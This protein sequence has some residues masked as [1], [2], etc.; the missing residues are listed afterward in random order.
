MSQTITPATTVP[1]SPR[2]TSARW[3]ALA[4]VV[5][6]A[7]AIYGA[8]GDPHPSAQQESAVPFICAV[9]VVVAAGLYGLLLPAGLR[10]VAA[11]RWSGAALTL[12]IVALVLT[13][14][15][16]WSGL[17]LVVG[18]AAAVLGAAGRRTATTGRGRATAAVVLGVLAVVACLV[19]SV[20]GN[21][22][23]AS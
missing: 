21:T 7:T 14:V 6:V 18:T 9:L 15:S 13:P 3:G 17:P 4:L 12:G 19:M 5:A 1:S 16:F 2:A 8:F 22:L 23:V 11:G 10:G 20:L